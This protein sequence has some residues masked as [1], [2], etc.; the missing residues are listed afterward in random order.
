LYVL[1][2]EGRCSLG[3]SASAGANDHSSGVAAHGHLGLGVL[4]LSVS[5]QETLCVRVGECVVC[6]I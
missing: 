3:Q 5:G 6:V 4:A 1:L 2:A